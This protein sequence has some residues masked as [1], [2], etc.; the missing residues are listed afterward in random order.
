M[1]DLKFV[2]INYRTFDNY[3]MSFF[4]LVISKPKSVFFRINFGSTVELSTL[5]SMA[6]CLISIQFSVKGHVIFK[7]CSKVTFDKF[8]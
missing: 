6:L 2:V 7:V 3:G 8:Q 4:Q 1:L 5:I